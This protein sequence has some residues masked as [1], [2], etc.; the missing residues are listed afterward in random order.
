MKKI[1]VTIRRDGTQRIE[2]M[3]AGG[4]ECIAFTEELEKRLGEAASPRELKPEY[5][6]GSEV[7]PE[8]ETEHEGS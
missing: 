5:H 6:S 8:R 7:A 3:G 4:D 2:V 1:Q